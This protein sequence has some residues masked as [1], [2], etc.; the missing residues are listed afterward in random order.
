M[1]PV[2]LIGD[3]V[4]P[5]DPTNLRANY[6]M[7]EIATEGNSKSRVDYAFAQP[8]AE[9][10][11]KIRADYVLGQPLCEGYSHIRVCCSFAQ[12]LFPV[13]PEAYMS[14]TPFPGF[15]NST[16]NPAIPAGKDPF[17]SALPGLTFDISK[18]PAFK[19]RISESP[20][21]MEVRNSLTEYPRWDFELNYEF[22]EDRTGANSS[23][24]TIMGFFLQMRGSYDSWLFKDPDDYQA[25][26]VLIGTGDAAT[27]EFPFVRNMGGFYERIGQV[28]TVNTVNIYANG[29]LVNPADYTITM[30]N[31]LIFDV[32]PAAGVIITGSY[33]Y[34]FVC[35]FIEDQM[36]FEKFADKLWSLQQ[37]EFRSIIA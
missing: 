10:Y 28:D 5:G 1:L 12:A 3:T 8:L 19:T 33:Q 23:L 13:G 31:R 4:G 26:D 25:T 6:A 9:G 15:G 21:G 22:L 16:T 34:Y 36:D 18:R 37:V 20:S 11:S 30:P 24:K 32:A 2:R 14:T 17:N 35:R 27:L 29:V 7:A